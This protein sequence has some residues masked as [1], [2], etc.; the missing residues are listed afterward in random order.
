MSGNPKPTLRREVGLGGA[1]L[2]GLGSIL[3]T[4]VFVG[5]GIAGGIA[6]SMVVVAI[7]LAGGLAFCNA[8][9]SAQLAAKHPVSG[10]TYEYGILLLGPRVGFVAGWMF[11]CAKSASAATAALGFASHLFH[12]SIIR[13]EQWVMPVAIAAVGSIVIVVAM[14]IRR[15]NL[16]NAIIVSLTIGGLL[17]FIVAGFSWMSGPNGESIGPVVDGMKSFS[18]ARDGVG[19]LEATALMFVAY[20]GYGRIATLGEEVRTPRTTIPRAIGITLVV[21]ATLYL[22]VAVVAIGLLGTD[23]LAAV[24]AATAAPLEVA[25]TMLETPWVRW[26]VAIAAVTAMLGVLLNLVL[27][28]SRVAFAMGRRGD[29][30]SGVARVRESTG[31]PIVAVILVGV[32]ITGLVTIGSVRT[33]WAFSA[34]TVLVYYG[35]TNLAALRLAPEDR[36]LP[37]AFAWFGLAGCGFLAFWVDWRIW[38]IGLGVILVGLM[39]RSVF[40]RFK[41]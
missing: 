29:L 13:N 7:V 20:T 11:L 19:L 33:T 16:V 15:A 40:R 3:G 1:V 30:P 37:R 23:G 18:V 12:A 2:L 38:T 6:G 10:G 17:A 36:F 27:G 39:W 5:I 4:G 25:A 41:G 32:I 21:S 34:F 31:T 8:A 26:V 14:G 24:T 35:I 22:L 9:S 28:L